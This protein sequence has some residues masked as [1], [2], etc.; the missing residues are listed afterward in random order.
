MRRQLFDESFAE[1]GASAS[2]CLQRNV[3]IVALRDEPPPP[4]VP[5]IAIQ[6]M[7]QGFAPT[8]EANLVGDLKYRGPEGVKQV[9]DPI[10]VDRRELAILDLGCGSGLAGVLFKPLAAS[11]VPALWSLLPKRS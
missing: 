4:R 8:F 5:D 2:E 1:A 6:Q 10:I 3:D 9:I 7:Y 11:L